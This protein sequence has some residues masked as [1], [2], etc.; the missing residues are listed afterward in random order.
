MRNCDLKLT[1]VVLILVTMHMQDKN[2]H[3]IERHLDSF[4]VLNVVVKPPFKVVAGVTVV[5]IISKARRR[6]T[7]ECLAYH[8][9][10]AHD[11]LQGSARIK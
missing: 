11:R 3:R 6:S 5:I 4:V 8:P 10:T 2:A 1:K 7:A 9:N